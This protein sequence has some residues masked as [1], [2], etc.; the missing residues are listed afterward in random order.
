MTDMVNNH[1]EMDLEQGGF[2][3]GTGSVTRAFILWTVLVFRGRVLG[4]T[5]CAVF[6]GLGELFD[7]ISAAT[8]AWFGKKWVFRKYYASTSTLCTSTLA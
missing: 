1:V 5:T 6:N 3:E 8:V 2:T 7:T 4:A